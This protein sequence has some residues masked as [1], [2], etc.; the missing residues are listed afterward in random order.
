M[1]VIFRPVLLHQHHLPMTGQSVNQRANVQAMSECNRGALADTSVADSC[2]VYM[3][4]V[5]EPVEQAFYRKVEAT[6][7]DRCEG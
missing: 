4:C 7:Q 1:S 6:L 5:A 3:R 2:A